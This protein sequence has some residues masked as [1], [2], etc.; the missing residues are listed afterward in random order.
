[1]IERRAE[2]K[3]WLHH[4]NENYLPGDRYDATGHPFWQGRLW[5]HLWA[6]VLRWEWH[7]RS[8]SCCI[9]LELDDLHETEVVL[10]LALPP[11]SVWF[12]FSGPLPKLIF[13]LMRMDY[14]GMEA[15]GGGIN[16]CQREFQISIHHSTLYW[17]FFDRVGEWNSTDPWWMSA[18]FDMQRFVMGA[19]ILIRETIQTAQVEVPMPEGTYAATATLERVTVPKRL[20][21]DD[22]FTVVKLDVPVGIPVP[23]KGEN[24]W[25]CGPDATFGRTGPATTIEE[26]IAGLVES[27][28][29][30]RKQRCGSHLYTERAA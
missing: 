9:S 24:S 4:S 22:V 23:G 10:H 6:M 28:L 29:S 20:W 27:I 12:G 5:L 8:T 25:D 30:T 3:V 14:A 21:T 16:D 1:M 18:S 17:K 26:A 15:R 7:F 13:R 2:P 19:Q 11:V